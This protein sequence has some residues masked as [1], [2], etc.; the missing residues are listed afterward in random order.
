ME[1][2]SHGPKLLKL[3]AEKTF[4]PSSCFCQVIGL[5]S[6][7]FMKRWLGLAVSSSSEKHLRVTSA[8]LVGIKNIY[9]YV[10]GFGCRFKLRKTDEPRSPK[11]KESGGGLN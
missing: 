11:I 7:I 1:P 8:R 6:R 5:V 2:S 4:P 9:E 3:W 10:A